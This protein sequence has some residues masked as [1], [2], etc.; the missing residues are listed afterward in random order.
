MNSCEPS[1]FLFF[2]VE[3]MEVPEA[4]RL[5]DLILTFEPRNKT[6]LEY[7]LALSDLKA[8][9]G[10]EHV[11][12]FLLYLWKEASPLLEAEEKADAEEKN[13]SSG[14]D[15]S[16]DSDE[17]QE[18]SDDDSPD[19]SGDE[20]DEGKLD[21]KGDDVAV[22][23]CPILPFPNHIGHLYIFKICAFCLSVL[24]RTWGC[25]VSKWI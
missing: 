4:L 8:E 5:A 9:E 16:D 23:N 2:E 6:I 14:E 22:R 21:D 12:T 7:R 13:G 24:A 1:F 3:D 20:V 17:G 18:A 11:L 15:D 25:A 19:E 10:V